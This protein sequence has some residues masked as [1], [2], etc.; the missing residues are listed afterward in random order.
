MRRRVAL[1]LLVAFVATSCRALVVPDPKGPQPSP[2]G[3]VSAAWWRN[4][5]RDYLDYAHDQFSPGS[6][7]NMINNAEWARR[8]HRPFNTAGITLADYA[9][10]FQRM[11]DFVDTADFDLTYMMNLWYGYRDVLPAD[12]R[13]AMEGHMRSFKYW[14]TDPQPTGTIDQR[15]YWSEN[16]RLLFHADEYLAGQAFPSDVSAATATPAHGTRS[17]RAGS[18]TRGS[19]RR[20]ASVSPSGTPT[21]TTRRPPTRS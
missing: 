16:H 17:G 14:F 6:Y 18:S 2:D 7:T 11:D 5:Q 8:N 4:Q 9:N 13:T 20:P 19:P 12:V 10:S 3:F 21:S 15:Y 1:I